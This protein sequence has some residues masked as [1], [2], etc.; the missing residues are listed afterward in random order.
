MVSSRVDG[1]AMAEVSVG[2]RTQSFIFG[3]MWSAENSQRREW[4]N[5][6]AL[7]SMGAAAVIGRQSRLRQ[8]NGNGNG[9]D[10]RIQTL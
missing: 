3:A 1:E 4:Q 7:V 8:G 10:L 6:K 9:K 2:G 5:T